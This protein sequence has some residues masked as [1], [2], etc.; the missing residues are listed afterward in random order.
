MS[1]LEQQ[2][3][4]ARLVTDPDFLQHFLLDPD[5][6]RREFGL[7]DGEIYDLLKVAEDGLDTFA[8]SL[9]WKRLRE[10]EKLLPVTKQV[11]GDGFRKLF[12]QFAPSLNPQSVKK[13]Y[14]DGVEFSR[15]VEKHDS[16]A[17]GDT[18]R[19]ERTR[20]TFFVEIQSFA[21]CRSRYDLEPITGAVS[22]TRTKIAMWFR[23]GRRVFHFVI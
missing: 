18:A 11:A 6:A 16:D 17:A 23:L 12:F 5:H 8:D 22:R 15:F 13:H 20:L 21:F 2:N 1:L 9:V 10:V 19:F 3:A 14:E 4:L 7:Q